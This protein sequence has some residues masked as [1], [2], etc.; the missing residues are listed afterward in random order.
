MKDSDYIT[1]SELAREWGV[2]H[3]WV[4][5]LIRQGRIKSRLMFGRRLIRQGRDASGTS[6]I[7]TEVETTLTSREPRFFVREGIKACMK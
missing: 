4:F 5:K 6:H 2:T 1:A 7:G 3:Q